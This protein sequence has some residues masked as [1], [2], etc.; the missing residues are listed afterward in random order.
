MS[1][2]AKE[3]VCYGLRFSHVLVKLK[4]ENGKKYVKML[5]KVE[6]DLKEYG[7]GN[8]YTMEAE[9]KDLPYLY[10]LFVNESDQKNFYAKHKNEKVYKDGKLTLIE[11]KAYIPSEYLTIEKEGGEA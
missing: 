10:F 11:E 8:V 5:Q 2:N 7:E 4:N 6:T 9:D 3:V 1:K